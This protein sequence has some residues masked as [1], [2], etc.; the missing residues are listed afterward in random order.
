MALRKRAAADDSSSEEDI[1][2]DKMVESKQEL[3]KIRKDREKKRAQLQQD[4]DKKLVGLLGHIEQ[5][6]KDHT[7]QL[8]TIKQQQVDRL[9]AAV[10]TRDGIDQ[11]ISEKLADL[12]LEGRNI[13]AMLEK[14]YQHRLEKAQSLATPVSEEGQTLGESR[15]VKKAK[16]EP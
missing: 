2:V 4:L 6:L 15:P 12:Q 16:I 9:T 10:E 1:N 13:A 3:D 14:A 7:Q 11:H 5:T 8:A